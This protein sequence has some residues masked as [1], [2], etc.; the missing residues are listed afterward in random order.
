M[1]HKGDHAIDFS[2]QNRIYV[3]A[4][5]VSWSLFIIFPYSQSKSATHYNTWPRLLKK[6][7][8]EKIHAKS[9][10]ISK[11][12]L[13]N[14]SFCN[15]GLKNIYWAPRKNSVDKN[16][17]SYSKDARNLPFNH[18]FPKEYVNCTN[19]SLHKRHKGYE[20]YS[21]PFQV[22]YFGSYFRVK[23]GRFL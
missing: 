23:K 7:D 22:Q 1:G 3:K 14:S 10:P 2:I 16:V 6:C 13:N 20:S 15:P 5:A 17:P 9:H 21:R 19:W 18:L 12:V 8:M 11:S 4:K